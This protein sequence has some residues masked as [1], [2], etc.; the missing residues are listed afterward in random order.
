MQPDDVFLIKENIIRDFIVAR[1][2]RLCVPSTGGLGL[3][4]GLGTRSHMVQRKILHAATKT[5]S[6]QL[7]K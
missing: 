5:W 7:G 2:L 3:I 6:S 4:P 1:W